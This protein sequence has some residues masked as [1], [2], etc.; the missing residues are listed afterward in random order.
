MGR[1]KKHRSPLPPIWESSDDLWAIVA[2]ILLE[3]DPPKPTGRKRITQRDAFD[4][5]IVRLRTGCQWNHLPKEY[6]DDSSVHR[7]FRAGSR[8]GSSTG[9]GRSSRKRVRIWMG[10]TGPGR[11]PTPPW[12]R[13]EKGDQIDPNPT[14]RAKN[15]VKRSLIVEAEGGP[16]G[17]VVAGANV[18]DAHLLDATIDAIVLARPP[19]EDGD[20]QHFC[21]DKGY[22]NETGW[23]AC[24]DAD[25]QPHITLIR[26]TRPPR[27]VAGV[28][29][30]VPWGPRP[31]GEEEP[32][33]PGPTQAGLW[34][35]LVPALLPVSGFEIDSQRRCE[36]ASTSVAPNPQF[37][38]P[39]TSYGN[40]SRS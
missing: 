9:S 17:V 4:A 27:P 23:G 13:P 14:D 28:A 18:P 10:A 40:C 29:V 5:I 25:Y 39:D 6:P 35:P 11:R 21:L 30:D 1:R 34:A 3:L 33:R 7:T 15:G 36:N 31:L 19:I 26:D 12:A 37:S 24:I 16:L 8:V 22:D 32:E 2:P 38:T 20:E